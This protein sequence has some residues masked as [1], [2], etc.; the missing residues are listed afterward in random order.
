MQDLQDG[1]V[2]SFDFRRCHGVI[3]HDIFGFHGSCK[4]HVVHPFGFFR[5]GIT[6]L[7]DDYDVVKFQSFR[8][9]D[10]G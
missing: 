1:I 2:V 3:G 5:H 8:R 10:G 7:V 6:V 4:C 9:M